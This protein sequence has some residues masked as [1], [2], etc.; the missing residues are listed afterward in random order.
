M[1]APRPAEPILFLKPSTAVL[2][3]PRTI[4]LPGFSTEVHHEVEMVL[5]VGTA[6]TG[7]GAREAQS[8]VDGV[9][10]G[11]DLTARDLQAKAKKAGEPWAVS[12]GFDGSAPLGTWSAVGALD[13]LRDLRILL[14]VNGKERQSGST[15]DLLFPL[16]ELLAT[17]SRYF[18]L[19]PGD[20]VFTGTPSGVGPLRPGDRLEA[21]LSGRSRLSAVVAAP[22]A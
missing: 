18:T 17:I 11:L 10:V 16:P 7:I 13:E 14:A 4:R 1:G 3:E 21:E 20:L 22:D 12:K 8:L 19:E 5:R 2:H 9:A 6:A 15:K